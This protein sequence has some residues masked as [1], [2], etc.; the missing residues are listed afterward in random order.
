[1]NIDDIYPSLSDLKKRAKSRLPFFAW[2]YLD[3]ATGVED[4]KNRNREELNKILFETRILKGEY[5][6]NQKTTF[7]GKTYS[8]PFGVAP[9][10]MSGMIWP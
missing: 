2:E 4:Q 8:H 7:L 1:M 6:P 9:V 5:V 3:S 10:G